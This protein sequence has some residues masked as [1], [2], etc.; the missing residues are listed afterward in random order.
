[1]LL[2]EARVFGQVFYSLSASLKSVEWL[3]YLEEDL[4][5]IARLADSESRSLTVRLDHSASFLQ[6]L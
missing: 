6:K 3:K 1:M 4:S 2:K 5:V